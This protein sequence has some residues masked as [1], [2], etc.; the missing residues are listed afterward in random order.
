MK[1]CKNDT[2]ISHLP[3]TQIHYFLKPLMSDLHTSY[4][5]YFLIILCVFPKNKAILLF[6]K[7]DFDATLLLKLQPVFQF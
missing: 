7:L 5:P 2:K 4:Y 1:S 3:F 6:R